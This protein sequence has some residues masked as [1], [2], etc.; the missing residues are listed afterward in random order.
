M[1]R[2]ACLRQEYA[3]LYPSIITGRWHTAAAVAG[4]V[5]AMS[6][7]NGGEDLELPERVLNEDHFLF[8][9][10]AARHGIWLGMRTR[11]TDRWTFDD[12]THGR[13]SR[14]RPVPAS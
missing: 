8:R 13:S 14:L 5:K 10:G 6:I 12:V 2:E 4:E 11:R 3:E 7:I 1:Q 9:G